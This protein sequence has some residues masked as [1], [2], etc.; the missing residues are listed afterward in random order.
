MINGLDAGK[1]SHQ[2]LWLRADEFLTV[3]Q[4]LLSRWHDGQSEKCIEAKIFRK[5]KIA[6]GGGIRTN[7]NK[8]KLMTKSPASKMKS[9]IIVNAP[10]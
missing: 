9:S 2:S 5:F 1:S 10:V 8:C 3:N 4:G 6:T 7:E